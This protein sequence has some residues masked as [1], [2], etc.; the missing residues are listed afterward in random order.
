MSEQRDEKFDE[1]RDEKQQEK[2][3]QEKSW[4]EKYRRD[5]LG[6]V[7]WAAI[8]IWVGIVL[9]LSNLGLFSNL[10]LPGQMRLDGWSIGFLGAGII[11]LLEALV[12]WLRPEYRRSLV[13]NLVVGFIFIGIGLGNIL[14]ADLVWPLILIA[15]GLA[16]I[17]RGFLR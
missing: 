14:G 5:P 15:L 12:R 10:N 1:K 7:T 13:G 17:L 16:I 3:P 4:E 8:L 6:T 11:L 9:L 2:S